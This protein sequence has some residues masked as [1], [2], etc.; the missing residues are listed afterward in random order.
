MR[1]RPVHTDDVR[2]PQPRDDSRFVD[3]PLDKIRPAEQRFAKELHG[4]GSIRAVLPRLVD[5]SH[6]P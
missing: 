1:P 3:E 4:H 2:V 5:L 6:S